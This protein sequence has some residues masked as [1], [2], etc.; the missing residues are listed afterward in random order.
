M[1]PLVCLGAGW[2][3]SSVVAETLSQ[4]SL[5][6]RLVHFGCHRRIFLDDSPQIGATVTKLEPTQQEVGSLLRRNP[7]L[8]LVGG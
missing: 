3:G 8:G 1:M 4:F 2:F 5:V 6:A 7:P